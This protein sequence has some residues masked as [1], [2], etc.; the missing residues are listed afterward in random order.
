MK[1]KK[2]KDYD[3]ELVAFAKRALHGLHESDTFVGIMDD[4]PLDSSRVE[5]LMHLGFA[6]LN[7]KLIIIPVPFGVDL[8]KKLVAVADKV[9]RY[10]AHDPHSLQ[11][12]MEQALS[13]LG[14]NTH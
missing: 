6:I 14:V 5:F 7:D 13:E 3:K 12:A 11:T 4:R 2:P 10:H 8:P 1:H 9:V